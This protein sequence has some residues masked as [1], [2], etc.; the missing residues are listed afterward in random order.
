MES[1]KLLGA[2]SD[3]VTGSKL[4]AKINNDD[5]IMVDCGGTQG[6]DL[7][8]NPDANKSLGV[9]LSS[10]SAIFITH[11]HY[12]HVG[13]LPHA[14]DFEGPIYMTKPSVPMARVMLADS[15]RLSPW[16]YNQAAVDKVMLKVIPVEYNQPIDVNGTIINFKDAGHIMG[17]ASIVMREK[18]GET[19]VF[20]G[21]LGNS[22]S[23][24]LRPTDYP[25]D[26]DNLVIESTY[27][28]SNHPDSNELLL[29]L[30]EIADATVAQD[31]ITLFASFAV[32]RTQG[33]IFALKM[34]MET[35]K[36][37]KMPVFVDSPMAIKMTEIYNSF[38]QFLSEEAR[39]QKDPFKF[40]G[41][42]NA[43]TGEQS[44]QIPKDGPAIIIAG[45]GMMNGG[46]IVDRAKIHLPRRQDIVVLSGYAAEGTLSRALAEG[47]TAVN[48]DGWSYPVNAG[49]V[50]LSSIS[51]H[52]DQNGILNAIRHANGGQKGVRTITINHGG[53]KQREAL[54]AII[55]IETDIYDIRF[56]ENG[57]AIDLHKNP[58]AA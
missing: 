39:A 11:T 56:A 50:Q 38:P 55:P 47:D 18:N 13:L 43:F 51:A 54:G 14:K 53:R 46:R 52:A 41:L 32:D 23:R 29:K 4:L 30:K 26:A 58:Q 34:L 42:V 19:T 57:K 17:S 2:G 45:S 1:I 25:D 10:V 22:P 31:G 15:A 5:T 28:D 16:L 20:S 24:I 12:D 8:N 27:G 36:I 40:K 48:I 49:I 33:L 37:K 3:Q 35:G 6:L 9:D 7:V 21:D 44:R